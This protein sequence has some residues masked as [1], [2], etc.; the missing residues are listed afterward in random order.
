MPIS[1]Q[2]NKHIQRV[3]IEAAKLATRESPTELQRVQRA[4]T[5]Y[6]LDEQTTLECFVEK[7]IRSCV[8][9]D[10]TRSSN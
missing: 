4:T 3:L 7:Q 5:L 6:I 9:P 2:R 1:T 8:F 10:D